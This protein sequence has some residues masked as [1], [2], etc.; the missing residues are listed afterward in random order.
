MEFLGSA[1]QVCKRRSRERD[2]NATRTLKRDSQPPTS[3]ACGST[4]CWTCWRMLKQKR[5]PC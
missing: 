1:I 2:E 4:E 3:P 5:C